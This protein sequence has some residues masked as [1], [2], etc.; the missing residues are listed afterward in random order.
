MIWGGSTTAKRESMAQAQDTMDKEDRWMGPTWSAISHS[1]GETL[2]IAA[3]VARHAVHGDVIALI[4][5]LGSGKTQFVRG[6]AVGLGLDDT[7]VS[8]PTFV[9][10][11]EYA[12]RDGRTVLVH[13]DAYRLTSDVDTETIGWD[14]KQA[15]FCDQAVVAIEWAEYLLDQIGE[16]VLVV[17]LDH[18]DYQQRLVTLRTAGTWTGRMPQLAH[19]LN[20]VVVAEVIRANDFATT[21]RCPICSEPVGSGSELFPFCSKRC[22]SL[23]LNRW[24]RGEYMISRSIEQSDLEASD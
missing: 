12:D 24:L 19:H 10:M 18:E 23:D 21:R 5:E 15:E 20:G 16:N 9:L 22:R 8:S 6:L 2:A 17:E 4:G 7:V 1:V 3:T 14:Q 11:H 13:L